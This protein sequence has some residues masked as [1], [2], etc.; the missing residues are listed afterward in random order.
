MA[1]DLL[2]MIFEQGGFE[3]MLGGSGFGIALGALKTTIHRKALES[4]ASI[5]DAKADWLVRQIHLLSYRLEEV[6]GNYSPFH[7]EEK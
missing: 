3:E 1:N 2:G 5:D 7:Y 6:T 4:V